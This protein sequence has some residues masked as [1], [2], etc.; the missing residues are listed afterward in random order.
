MKRRKIRP[1]DRL[2]ARTRRVR[3][4]GL[5]MTAAQVRAEL[6]RVD[7]RMVSL[8]RDI[9]EHLPA[10]DA[11]RLDF[12][13]FYARWHS[14]YQS[15]R[16]DWLAWGSNVDQAQNFDAELDAWR[17]RYSDATGLVPTTPTTSRTVPRGLGLGLPSTSTVLVG[18]G[19]VAILAAGAYGT[20]RG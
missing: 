10:N 5:Y 19:I 4:A 17:T 12:A 14:F 2:R 13:S 8:K 3:V 11:M 16:A 18:L 9:A 7:V 20:G 15:A 1:S 6:D